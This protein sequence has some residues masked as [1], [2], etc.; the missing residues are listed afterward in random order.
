M[1]Q[2][3]TGTTVIVAD[4][5]TENTIVIA[6]S[7]VCVAV[8]VIVIAI[9][10]YCYKVKDRYRNFHEGFVSHST[11]TCREAFVYTVMSCLSI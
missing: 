8:I 7:V 2:Y 3:R 10:I 9:L 11:T 4:N 5:P 1:E 6:L